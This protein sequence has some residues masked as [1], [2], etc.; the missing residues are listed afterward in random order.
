MLVIV[1]V[2]REH[3][4]HWQLLYTALTLLQPASQPA[5]QYGAEPVSN[6]DQ[7]GV[8]CWASGIIAPDN[9]NT[10]NI[11][12]SIAVLAIV[13]VCLQAVTLYLISGEERRGEIVRTVL[14]SDSDSQY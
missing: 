6:S 12:S 7:S 8:V 14:G 11:L 10:I 4:S 2:E 13:L 1:R 5:V 3:S 9:T